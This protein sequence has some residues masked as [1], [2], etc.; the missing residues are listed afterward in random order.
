VLTPTVLEI[1]LELASLQLEPRSCCKL[2]LS[3]CRHPI[4]FFASYHIS[5]LD[6][7]FLLELSLA[8]AIALFM[9]GSN[10]LRLRR[11]FS[12]GVRYARAER[13]YSWSNSL[14]TQAV[15]ETEFSEALG[16]IASWRQWSVKGPSQIGQWSTLCSAMLSLEASE[17]SPR[18][19]L[20][21]NHS[22]GTI[23][24]P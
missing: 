23:G 16:R 19:W 22:M 12:A 20:D 17:R 18:V 8:D 15:S 9:W 7:I 5:F 1:S 4:L 13:W 2:N 3:L 14:S 11:G 10:G 24:L 21:C 6:C